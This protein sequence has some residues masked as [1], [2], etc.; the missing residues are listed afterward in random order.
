[1]NR[2]LVLDSLRG[3]AAIL[4]VIFH[5]LYRYGEIYGHD[6]SS[7]DWVEYGE[8]G[9]SLFF[10][11]SG[12]VIYWTISKLNKPMDFIVS[13]FS[14]LY[15]V[16]WAS[17]IFTYFIVL[18]FGLEGREIPLE[19]AALN[20]LMFHEYLYV[21]HVDGVYWTLTIELTFYFW[22]FVFY[23]AKKLEYLEY[24]FIIMSY[25]SVLNYYD[26]VQVPYLIS[27]VLILDHISLFLIGII[28]FKYINY[29]ASIKG[30]ILALLAL[31]SLFLS[32]DDGLIVAIIAISFFIVLKL[33]I[34]FL[35]GKIFIFFGSISYSLYL[36]HQ[37]FGYVV[38]TQSYEYGLP[39]WFGIA[40]AFTLSVILAYFLTRFIEQ[41]AASKIK[42]YYSKKS[43]SNKEVRSIYE[44]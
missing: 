6:F 17:L 43:S 24:V 7:A 31:L 22:I 37:N 10:M 2:L 41:P 1:M 23:L 30:S 40:V 13:R 33:K 29:G 35:E 18:F 27:K 34:P 4:V 9:V 36:I 12:F 32:S 14:R 19:L 39:S 11:I 44:R 20:S 21:P 15:P 5:Y 28:A 26:F 3:I 42:S 16:F 38:I 25:L 8:H